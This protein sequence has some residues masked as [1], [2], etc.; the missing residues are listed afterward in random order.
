[1]MT[2]AA[3]LEDFRLRFL[4]PWGEEL[5]PDVIRGGPKD[6]MRELPQRRR[7]SKSLTRRLAAPS[8]VPG[9]ERPGKNL[10]MAADRAPA[11]IPA[12]LVDCADFLRVAT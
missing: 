1:M 11:S 5:A 12:N 4:L 8:P 7:K 2:D 10:I 3:F 9:E 6:R